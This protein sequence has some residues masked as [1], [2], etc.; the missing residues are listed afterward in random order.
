MK[1]ESKAEVKKKSIRNNQ[2]LYL[3][4]WQRGACRGHNNIS[5]AASDPTKREREKKRSE[6]L[7]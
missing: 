5:S 2:T 6:R 7:E 1:F 3:E 4:K